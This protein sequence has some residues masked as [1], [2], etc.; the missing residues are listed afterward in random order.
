MSGLRVHGGGEELHHRGQVSAQLPQRRHYQTAAHGR[1]GGRWDAKHSRTEDWHI[2]TFADLLSASVSHAQYASASLCFM[3]VTLCVCVCLCALVCVCSGKHYGCIVRKKVMLLEELKRDT[4]EFGGFG[5]LLGS[6]VFL[7][8]CF[9]FAGW[10]GFDF[11]LNRA[12]TSMFLPFLFFFLF[13]WFKG[14]HPRQKHVF[15]QTSGKKTS[16]MHIKVFIL[17]LCLFTSVD[18]S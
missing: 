1:A 9:L 4:P 18:F 10:F 16:K 3:S 2:D 15:F 7:L 12:L 8:C 5:S 17:L 14:R 6:V 11:F 13:H